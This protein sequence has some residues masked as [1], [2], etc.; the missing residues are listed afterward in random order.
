ME[1]AK[2]FDTAR[3]ING[4]TGADKGIVLTGEG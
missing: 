1:K 2:P 3:Y 4:E